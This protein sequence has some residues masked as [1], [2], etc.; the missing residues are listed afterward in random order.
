MLSA[1][2]LSFWGLGAARPPFDPVGQ[3]GGPSESGEVV[4]PAMLAS[5]GY[6]PF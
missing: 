6:P 1:G 5:P 3:L 2:V 4:P